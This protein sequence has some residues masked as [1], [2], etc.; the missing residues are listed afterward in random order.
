MTDLQCPARFFVGAPQRGPDVDFWRRAL[1]TE[2]LVAEY[3]LRGT[4]AEVT[5]LVEL[6]DRHRGEAVLV[7][8][9]PGA[10]VVAGAGVGELLASEVDSSGVLRT[11]TYQLD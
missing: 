6:A 1:R 10:P 11:G 2:G 4:A 3:D 5:S 8:V 7:L 9:D